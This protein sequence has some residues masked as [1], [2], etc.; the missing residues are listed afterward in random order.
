MKRNLRCM[1]LLLA[2]ILLLLP[3]LLFS[4]DVLT[5][6]KGKL[7]IYFLDL[8]VD[9]FATD[10]S[11]DATILIAPEGEVMLIDSGHPQ[12]GS[13]V[14]EALNKLGV[15]HID[16]FVA[17]HPHIDHIGAFPQ[18]AEAFS[19]GKVYRSSIVYNSSHQ[20][21]FLH[22]IQEK[23]LDAEILSE[24]DSFSFGSAIEIKIYN[25]S[26]PINY[27]KN[28][29]DNCTSFINN[30]SLAMRLSYGKSSA[31]F[32]G[33]LYL[34]QERE[35]V[36]KYGDELQSDVIKANHHGGK[37][38]NSLRWIKTIQPEIVVA[39]HDTL[40]SMSV[41]TNYKKYGAE[42]HLT[43]LNG[44]VRVVMD[45]KKNYTVTDTTQSW[46]N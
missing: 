11:G 38:S 35:L 26:E 41:Y 29:P 36:L 7:N 14:I 18:I 28:Y 19:I 13:Q 1:A 34:V 4:Q 20:A 15:D 27:P 12:C 46:M 6:E 33:D 24:G 42:Y 16:Y 32:S 31:W 22:S 23:N 45:D 44:T 3:T 5:R 9:E 21:N 17:S 30:Q 43:Y 10:K 37:T 8:G 25:P 39:M 2:I 40:D